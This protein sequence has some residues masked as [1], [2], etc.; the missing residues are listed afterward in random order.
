MSE[1]H[2]VLTRIGQTLVVTLE[3]AADAGCLEGAS[4][5][6]AEESARQSA[7]NV[8]RSAGVM[9]A[10]SGSTIIQVS[11]P[12]PSILSDLSAGAPTMRHAW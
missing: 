3:G 5:A 7:N 9:P 8:G 4:E 1:G 2:F 12:L 6:L 11:A 10:A